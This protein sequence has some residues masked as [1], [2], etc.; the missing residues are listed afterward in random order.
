MSYNI[1]TWKVKKIENLSIPLSSFFT[2]L[3]TDWHPKKEYDENGILTLEMGEGTRVV[4]KVVDG[5]LHVTD[6]EC[7]G[8]GSG[9]SMNLIIEPAL[10]ESTGGLVASCVWEG[11]DSINQLIVKDGNVEWKDIEI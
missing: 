2:N 7:H 4:G 10:K 11:S 3:R 5:I 6:I 9:I 1:D 8:E